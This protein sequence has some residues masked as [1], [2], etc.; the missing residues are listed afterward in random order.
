MKIDRRSFLSLGIGAAAGTVLSPLPWKL[1]DDLSIWTQ[2]WPWTPVPEDGEISY[3]KSVS[4]VCRGGCGMAVRKVED[5]A[6][7]VEGLPGYP[8]NDGS[9][10]PLCLSNIQLLYGPTRIQSPLKRVGN[11]GEGRWEKITWEQALTEVSR[12]LSDV[13]SQGRPEA[14]SCI[15]DR[16]TGTVPALF[17]RFLTAYG[18][19]N[20]M[21]TPTYFDAYE[22]ALKLMHGVDDYMVGV[23]AE[24]ASY[25][26]SFGSGI[27]EGWG[28]PVRMF[29]AHSLWKEKKVPLIQFDSRLSN[30]AAK[31][32]HWIPVEPGTEAVLAL[33]LAHVII[34][35]SLYN[36]EFVTKY[37]TG[38]ED[39]EDDGG[40]TQKGFK[41]IILEEYSP[42]YVSR[43]TGVSSNV[44]ARVAREFAG[45][46]SPLAIGGRNAGLTPGSIHDVIAVHA[47]NALVGSVNRKGGVWAMMKPDYIKWNKPGLDST[48]EKG[49]ATTRVD[50]AGGEQFPHSRNLVSRLPSV[51]NAAEKCPVEILFVAEANPAYTL[52]DTDKVRAALEKIPCIVSFSPYMDETALMAD[53]VLPNHA[54]LERYEDIP[55]PPAMNQPMIGL[56][57]PV[58]QPLYNTRHVGDTLMQLAGK[59]GAPMA[60]AFPWENYEACLRETLGGRYWRSMEEEGFIANETYAPHPWEDAFEESG[61][62]FVFMSEACRYGESGSGFHHVSLEGDS[63]TYPLVLVPYDSMRLTG[64]PISDPPFMMKTVEDTILRDKDI[65]VHVNPKTAGKAGLEEGSR[66]VLETPKGKAKVRIHVFEGVKPGVIAIAR[67]LGHADT[68]M[69]MAGKGVNVNRLIGPVEDPISGFD[70]AYGIRAKLTVA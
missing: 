51:I 25:V 36:E 62:K 1:T 16:D 32:D 24:H 15:I 43:V 30:T 9:V 14:L 29:K 67:G 10:C 26:L 58:V 20:F 4:G 53:Y 66:A 38:F 5:R 65:F 7:K 45:A 2:M 69:Y 42:R 39:W 35:E 52:P 68:N 61:K 33:G 18:S 31:A 21:Y 47:L 23:D 49:M 44:I 40:T 46:I 57:R 12:K 41:S 11:R 60:D 6:I 59:V 3:V 70:A 55:A 28:T 34:K 8:A 13:R 64:G 54:H 63:G 22:V 19:P 50:G 27:I 48:A 17:E 56:S 37:A